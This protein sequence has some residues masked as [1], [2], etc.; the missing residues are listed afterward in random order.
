[1]SG[2]QE[3]HPAKLASRRVRHSETMSS[4]GMSERLQDAH[5]TTERNVEVVRLRAEGSTMQEIADRFDISRQRVEQIINR[6]RHAARQHVRRAVSA[7]M[8]IPEACEDCGESGALEAHHPDYLRPLYVFWLCASCHVE[9]D[10]AD[11]G[12]FNGPHRLTA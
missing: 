7:G 4:L 5:G 1:M 9:A 11:S 6:E 3:N 2:S 12:R 8:R 10:I